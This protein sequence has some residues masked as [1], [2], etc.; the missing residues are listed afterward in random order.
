[1]NQCFTILWQDEV[2]ALQVM[3]TNGEWIDAL[4]IPGCL[5]VK[6][7]RPLFT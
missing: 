2:P 1:M 4:P 5:V 3:N 7:E 6:Y